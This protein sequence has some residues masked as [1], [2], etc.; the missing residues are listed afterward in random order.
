MLFNIFINMLNVGALYTF[1]KFA[2][3]TKLG[4][5]GIADT[6]GCC[7]PIQMDLKMLNEW[8]DVN[9][10]WFNKVPSSAPGEEQPGHAGGLPAGKQLDRRR[11]G[12][13][14]GHQVDYKLAVYV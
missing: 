3:E 13:P 2:D 5:E 11:S 1:C 7:I 9:L 10:T 12:D 8:A 4:E 6:S 14:G